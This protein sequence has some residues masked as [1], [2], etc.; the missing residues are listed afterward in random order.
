MTFASHLLTTSP[1]DS[2][3]PELGGSPLNVV[4]DKVTQLYDI[5]RS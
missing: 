3:Y 1:V 5:Y 4:A 2:I